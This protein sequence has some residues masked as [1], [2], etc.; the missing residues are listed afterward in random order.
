MPKGIRRAAEKTS[1]VEDGASIPRG[2]VAERLEIDGLAHVA[3]SW[4]AAEELAP[5]VTPGERAVL[6]LLLTGASNAQIARA[7]GASPRTIANQ[8]ASLLRKVGAGSRYE[9]MARCASGGR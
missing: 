1:T 5:A 9:L 8:V 2:L 6:D 4:A 7:R 3:F